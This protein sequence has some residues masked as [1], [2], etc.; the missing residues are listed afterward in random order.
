MKQWAAI[1][2]NSTPLA[3]MDN[4]AM[5][6]PAIATPSDIHSSDIIVLV[7]VLVVGSVEGSFAMLCVSHLIILG[8]LVLTGLA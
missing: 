3:S 1:T 4:A 2:I 7:P 5:T 6:Q 8:V